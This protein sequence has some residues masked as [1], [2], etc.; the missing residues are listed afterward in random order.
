MIPES[1]YFVYARE[2]TRLALLSEDPD[3]REDLMQ[4]ARDWMAVAMA[5]AQTLEQS[6]LSQ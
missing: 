5:D 6:V 3:V 2:C 4:M 1:P